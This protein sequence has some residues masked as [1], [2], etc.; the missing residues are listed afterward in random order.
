V[1]APYDWNEQ[2]DRRIERNVCPICHHR[3]LQGVEFDPDRLNAVCD[4]Q[5]C[6]LRFLVRDSPTEPWRAD[7]S[8]TPWRYRPWGAP[9]P[10]AAEELGAGVRPLRVQINGSEIVEGKLSGIV[11]G[12]LKLVDAKGKTRR[13]PSANVTAYA[14]RPGND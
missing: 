6:P 11:G 5:D 4:N 14:L 13:I 9:D 1:S 8:V 12:E 7:E 2:G 10:W 3:V